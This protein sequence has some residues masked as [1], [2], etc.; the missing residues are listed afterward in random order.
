MASTTPEY[1]DIRRL[2]ATREGVVGA[3]LIDENGH[4]S[5]LQY[6]E[7]CARGVD[8]VLQLIG[9][10][11]DY[12]NVRRMGV[13]AAEHHMHY[14][15][16]LLQED[17]WAIHP[18]VLA[19]SAK[20]FHVVS[21]MVSTSRRQLA[22]SMETVYVHVDLESRRPVAMPDDVLAPLVRLEEEHRSVDLGLPLHAFTGR[23]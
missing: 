13:F 22:C 11:D 18:Q 7:L 9:I 4:V 6:F 23:G 2:R 10:S 5:I 12:R 3:E 20:A 17:G 16:E 19:H 14:S 15:A 1:D 8:D 21:L